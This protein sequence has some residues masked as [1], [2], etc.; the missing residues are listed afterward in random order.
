M[1]ARSARATPATPETV[2]I[3]GASSGIGRALAVVYG[4]RGAHVALA[5]R[6]AD[7]LE[8]VA[9][10]VRRVGGRA[11]VLPVDIADPEAAAETVRKA[12][13]ALGSLDM[14]IANAGIA[15]NRHATTLRWKDVN[16]V[17]D[18]NVRGTMATLLAAIPIFLAQQ[19]GHLVGVTSL[20]GRSGLP[21]AGAYSASKA[22]VSTFLETLRV[23]LAG[24]N[25]KVTDVQPGF[26]DTPILEGMR[27]PMPF[28]WPVEKAALTIVKRLEHAPAVIAFPLSMDILTAL[29]RAVPPFI[30][31]RVIRL[32]AQPR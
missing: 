4:R 1:K 9:A 22:A 24:A 15:R 28:R 13:G 16:A 14:V 26:V 23:D 17:L 27:H 20:A 32:V 29:G 31:D 5:A 25:I 21:G 7:A 18:V 19:R 6:R 30:Y 8:E 10:V 11:T 12:E 3:T 2:L